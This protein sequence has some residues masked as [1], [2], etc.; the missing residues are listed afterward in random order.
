[1]PFDCCPVYA[2]Q[3]LAYNRNLCL[4]TFH[5]KSFLCINCKFSVLGPLLFR[6]RW[7]SSI[8]SFIWLFENHF[9][10]VT[11]VSSKV[12]ITSF[13][14]SLTKKGVLL[15]AQ[16]VRY[17]LFITVKP[18]NGGHLRVLTKV[19]AIRRCPLYRGFSNNRNFV[20]FWLLYSI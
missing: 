1:M 2:F 4:I 5:M 16:P 11:P 17:V 12:F 19:S 3:Y 9:T 8:L 7:H 15:C 18:P 6:R 13:V 10:R 14:L 20:R